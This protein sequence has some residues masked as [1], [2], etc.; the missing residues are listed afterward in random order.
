MGNEA[1][2]TPKSSFSDDHADN[3]RRRRKNSHNPGGGPTE[4]SFLIDNVCTNF[5]L[6]KTYNRNLSGSFGTYSDD[7][8]D[9]EDYSSRG[10]RH[11]GRHR[12]NKNS[13][14]DS[15]VSTSLT[16]DYSKGGGPGISGDGEEDREGSMDEDDDTLDED[17]YKDGSSSVL[18]DAVS[19]TGGAPVPLGKPLASS[20]ARRCYFTKG[21]IGK[22]TQH[23]EGLTLTG[24]VVLMLA[25]AMKLKGCPTI[26]DEDL[27]RVEQTYP[28]Q[29]SRLPD[30]L[31]LSSGWRRISKYCH[32]SNKPIPDGVPFFHSKERLHAASG[33]FY[34]L[35][36]SSVGMIRPI[37]VEPLT[38]DNLV[39]LETDY[40]MPCDAAPP[41]LI[42]DPSQ[43]ILVD[44]FCFFSGG[45][46]NTEEDVYYE[47]D[48]DGNPIFM[49]AFL[50]PSLTPEELYRLNTNGDGGF[51]NVQEVEEVES[52]YDLTERDFDDLKLYHLG[53]CRALPQY[54]LRPEAWRKVLPYRFREA[55]EQA[56]GR[57][58]EVEKHRGGPQPPTLTTFDNSGFEGGGGA[59]PPF[60]TSGVLPPGYEQQQQ[61]QQQQQHGPNPAFDGS[62]QP[63]QFDIPLQQAPYESANQQQPYDVGGNHPYDM[64]PPIQTQVFDFDGPH[65]DE[66]QQQQHRGQN[67]SSYFNFEQSPQHQQQQPRH[68]RDESLT[69]LQSFHLQPV[70]SPQQQPQNAPF[71]TSFYQ[72]NP[73]NIQYFDPEMGF[74]EPEMPLPIPHDQSRRHLAKQKEREREIREEG[75]FISSVMCDS[76]PID[77]ALAGLHDPDN[78]MPSPLRNVV[79]ASPFHSGSVVA[80]PTRAGGSVATPTGLDVTPPGG[81]ME[82][83]PTAEDPPGI[84]LMEVAPPEVVR[85]A[86]AEVPEDEA[87]QAQLR[88]VV[89]G[90]PPSLQM[91]PPPPPDPPSIIDAPQGLEGEEEE[92]VV[93]TP[94][95]VPTFTTPEKQSAKEEA[96]EENKDSSSPAHTNL[97]QQSLR[98]IPSEAETVPG[99]ITAA[100]SV[101]SPKALEV[102]VLPAEDKQAEKD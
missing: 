10:G 68:N 16:D 3:P 63:P 24:N 84:V 9:G 62:Q 81:V 74:Q 37:D 83:H 35:L 53:P 99:V 76:Q 61:Q 46:I 70:T 47:A 44:K 38:R 67:S 23:Y 31:L 80:S 79:N 60:D 50:S 58:M 72:S 59:P 73:P 77:E 21:G 88:E 78:G 8:S 36:A 48:F 64:T 29:F 30:E 4:S 85:V 39:V 25:T 40:A 51:K 49:L 86:S 5:F 14:L 66:G 55:K 101:A 100:P 20:F 93:P 98:E 65:Q 102:T 6:H 22:S 13:D 41:E 18:S 87:R 28:N 92:E 32:F 96:E 57:A 90:E 45:P 42:Q 1:S 75:A 19:G 15:L 11:D 56:L 33:G 27:R 94:V 91:A 7:D 95:P 17:K 52:V 69:S 54:V 97:E 2:K 12:R 71:P 43:W 34:F 26:C 89:D 82:G